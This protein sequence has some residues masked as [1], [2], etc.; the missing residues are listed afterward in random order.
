MNSEH[1]RPEEWR[2]ARYERILVATDG[3]E[4]SERAATPTRF[5]S[6]GP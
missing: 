4:C 6:R 1:D 5:T 2:T 3:S